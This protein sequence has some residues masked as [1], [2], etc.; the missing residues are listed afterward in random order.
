MS[1]LVKRFFSV[2]PAVGL[3]LVALKLLG[4]VNA[5]WWLVTLPL[6]LGVAM[7]LVIILGVSVAATVI[8]VANL[9]KLQAA[10]AKAK[11]LPNTKHKRPT[12]LN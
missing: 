3:A 4:V 7:A 8:V 1:P 5:P 6:W 11:A 12:G 9:S 10:A 2:L